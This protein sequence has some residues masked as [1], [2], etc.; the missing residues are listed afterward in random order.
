M[1]GLEG[2]GAHDTVFRRVVGFL[3]LK[4][5]EDPPPRDA[6]VLR[7]EA[8]RER[9][10]LDSGRPV[11]RVPVSTAVLPMQDPVTHAPLRWPDGTVRYRAVGPQD[12]GVGDA[13]KVTELHLRNIALSPMGFGTIATAGVVLILPRQVKRKIGPAPVD[14]ADPALAALLAAG[15]V[16][17]GGAGAGAGAGGA[18]AGARQDWL[19]WQPL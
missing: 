12:V 7:D 14:A 18:G 5:S 4:D 8:G 2:G 3:V 19:R 9:I 17:A 6:D 11:Y 15:G 1:D 13:L 10:W 16:G